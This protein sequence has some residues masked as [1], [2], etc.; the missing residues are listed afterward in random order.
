M[1]G[2]DAPALSEGPLCDNTGALGGTGGSVYLSSRSGTLTIASGTTIQAGNGGRGGDCTANGDPAEAR[3][4][5]G[6]NGGGVYV[7]GQ[8]VMVGN[9]VKLIR[10]NGG[11]GGTAHAIGYVIL[12][13]GAIVGNPTEEGANGGKGGEAI[14]DGG[15]GADCV[16]GVDDA[17]GNIW[18]IGADSHKRGDGGD[19]DALGGD[20]GAGADCCAEKRPGGDG[21]KKG[22]AVA[23]G[24]QIG[25]RGLGGNGKVGG[26]TSLGSDGGDG[27]GPGAGGTGGMGTGSGDPEDLEDGDDGSDGELCADLEFWY[28]YFSSIPD[29]NI[30]PGA[31]LDLGVYD[32]TQTTQTGT[33]A[34][35]FQTPQEFG[36]E[37]VQYFKSGSFLFVGPG[38]LQINL[39]SLLPEFPTALIQ[40]LLDLL[41]NEAN[42]VELVGYYQ[43]EEVARVGSYPWVDTSDPHCLPSSSSGC[44]QV[45]TL[46]PVPEGVPYCDSFAFLTTG[47]FWLYHWD[48]L[49]VDP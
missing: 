6:G 3:A 46:P 31:D 30:E 49:I 2:A 32:E 44:Q 38:G 26:A 11:A 4:G 28:I 16:C 24:G 25:G 10:G 40:T 22:D 33:V 17:R 13:P 42:C 45:L 34:A 23:T 20:G 36:G 7:G 48:L 37:T 8:T 35:H 9:N 21:G 41:C 18:P 5:K 19:A 14:A 47:Q 27:L 1:D 15:L 39:T 43:G 12:E 29:G